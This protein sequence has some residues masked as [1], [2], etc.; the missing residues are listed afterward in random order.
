MN[1]NLIYKIVNLY[2]HAIYKNVQNAN[3]KILAISIQFQM[4]SAVR[5]AVM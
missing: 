2:T 3:E 1:Y 4:A 5:C